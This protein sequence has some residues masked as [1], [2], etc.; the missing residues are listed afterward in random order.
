M[1]IRWSKG[2]AAIMVAG[3]LLCGCLSFH[4]RLTVSQA[5]EQG[6]HLAESRLPQPY[7]SLK[8][9][10]AR[11]RPPAPGGW[12]F[13]HPEAPQRMAA[14]QQARPRRPKADRAVIYIQPLQL[15][16]LRGEKEPV[17]SSLVKATGDFCRAMTGL[18]VRLRPTLFLP[19]LPEQA[20]VD[21]PQ[22]GRQLRAPYL[23]SRVLL[24]KMPADALAIIGITTADLA[25]G[26][27]YDFVYGQ[28]SLRYGVAVVSLF[29]QG[30]WTD[31]PAL[32]LSRHL[33]T[34]GHELGHL[35]GLRHCTAYECLMNGSAH[36]A[37]AD[38]RP[39]FF[40]P[41]CLQKLCWNLDIAPEQYLGDLRDFFR[42]RDMGAEADRAQRLLGL[43]PPS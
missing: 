24:E 38:A 30:D 5:L 22:G 8:P 39:F 43:L 13:L 32:V 15:A 29:R 12:L 23:L 7:Q 26:K 9:G 34:V 17:P 3:I 27:G 1:L 2:I 35:L 14:Y 25:P 41:V 37:E 36:R 21:D 28:S 42:R 16:P 20:W 6:Q 33:R 10:F 18:T 11:K 19:D 4:G 31:S 40:C